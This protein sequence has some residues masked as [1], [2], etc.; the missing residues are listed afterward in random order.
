M[1][2]TNS[3]ELNKYTD[4]KTAVALGS[5]DAMHKGHLEVIGQA[6]A[7]AKEKGIYSLVQLFETVPKLDVAAINTLSARIGIVKELG[8]N[9]VVVEPFD[10]DFKNT[11]PEHFVKQYLSEIYNASAVFAGDN[12]RF[13]HKASG[14][15]DKLR[16][17][18]SKYGITTK[19]IECVKQG[20]VISSTRIRES[21]RQGNVEAAAQLMTRPYMLEGKVVHGRGVGHTIG[22][23]TANIEIPKNLIIPKDGVYL[24]DVTV[25]GQNFKG[26]TNIGSKPTVDVR[27]KNIETYIEGFDDDIY[28]TTIKLEFLKF[29]RNIKKFDSL[30]EL[31][32]QL[33]KDK[34]QL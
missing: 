17:E 19:I 26:I 7:F 6:V 28:D 16:K 30:D 1:I 15:A 27:E 24:T 23:P 13:G 22:F 2:V 14:N 12:Y 4:R 18:C 31:K 33:K 8:V 21:I 34:K 32:K 3:N 29:I 11:S 25:L 9:I 5:F 10:D 20:E